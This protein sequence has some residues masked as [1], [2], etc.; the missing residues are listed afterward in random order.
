MSVGRLRLPELPVVHSAAPH[1]DPQ[2]AGGQEHAQRPA[3]R[4][5]HPARAAGTGPALRLSAHRHARRHDHRGHEGSPHECNHAVVLVMVVV[6]VV[7]VVVVVRQRLCHS[8]HHHA[9]C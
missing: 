1:H 3:V 7:V 2:L 4:R 6:A 5:L 9:H 8:T